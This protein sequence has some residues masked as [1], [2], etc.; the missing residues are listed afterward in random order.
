MAATATAAE[1]IPK[2]SAN[3]L[4][5]LMTK[6]LQKQIQSFACVQFHSFYPFVLMIPKK[7]AKVNSHPKNPG[8]KK[9]LF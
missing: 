3:V 6:R 5:F 7:T 9:L 1:T 4:F 2:I 8:R